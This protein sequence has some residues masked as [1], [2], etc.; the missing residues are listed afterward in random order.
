M[1]SLKSSSIFTASNSI[2]L[3]IFIFIFLGVGMF[4]LIQKTTEKNNQ[5]KLE[6]QNRIVEEKNILN[7]PEPLQ[8]SGVANINNVENNNNN[9]AFNTDYNTVTE[10][11]KDEV[12]LFIKKD[13]TRP[14]MYSHS[15]VYIPPFNA[16]KETRCVTRQVNRPNETNVV[17]SCL[18]SELVKASSD[19]SF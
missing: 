7:T 13:E 12:G 14:E 16:G 17:Q 15:P 18:N 5:D 2:P 4:F 11:F 1:K 3:I 6:K 9:D 10:T 8:S 19:A